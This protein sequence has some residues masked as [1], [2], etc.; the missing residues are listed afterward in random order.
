MRDVKNNVMLLVI[1]LIVF[2]EDSDLV[3]GSEV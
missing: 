1:C 2:W 3:I